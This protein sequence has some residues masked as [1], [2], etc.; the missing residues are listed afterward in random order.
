MKTPSTDAF[1]LRAAVSLAYCLALMG[2]VSSANAL[3][4]TYPIVHT[5]VTAAYDHQGSINLPGKDSPYF[6]QDAH[7]LNNPPAY[8]D[9]GDGTV[10]D[11]VTGLTWMQDMGAKMTWGEAQAK[12]AT[13][14]K[15]QFQDWRIPNMKTLFSLS[16]YTGR[17]FGERVITPFINTTYFKQPKGDT[18]RDEREIDAQTW[19]S[20]LYTGAT[21]GNNAPS[22]FGMNFVDGRVKSYPLINRRKGEDN[23]MYFRFVRGNTVYGINQFQQHA[24]GTISDNATG[25]MWQTRDSEKALDW[26]GALSYCTKLPLAGRTDWRVPS[27][28]ELHSLVDYT[29]SPQISSSPS[30]DPMFHTSQITQSDGSRNYPYYWS[31]TTLLDGPRPGNQ[32]A[33]LPF[34][35][36]SAQVRGQIVDAHGAGAVRSDPKTGSAADYP[37]YFGP[38]GDQQQVYNYVRCVRSIP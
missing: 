5:G 20:D 32:A 8:R 9:N 36:A 15:G 2:S 38:Q 7:H 11:L 4:R 16:L 24:D 37:K 12:L 6:G 14:N 31:A 27:I 1:T 10:S 18:L 19:S 33:Y 29:R 23:R 13:L 25:L 17:A 30:I 3:A 21:M 34:G 22:R 35:I 28:K 26:Q